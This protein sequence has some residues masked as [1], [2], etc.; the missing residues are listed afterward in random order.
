VTVEPCEDFR[1]GICLESDIDGFKT[2]ACRVNKWQDCSAQGNSQDCGNS[3]RRDCKWVDKKCVAKYPPGFDFWE[4]GDA[5]SICSS[6][7]VQCTVTYEK[8]LASEKKCVQNCECL[9]SS[10]KNNQNQ[11]CVSLGDCGSKTNYLG[12][13]G[14]H[15]GG[16]VYSGTTEKTSSS[17][18]SA[19]SS[20]TATSTT[21]KTNSS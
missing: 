17:G 19:S 8:K 18:S 11:I 7:N 14:Y 13:A 2:A 16:A 6:A 1:Q 10:W 9:E 21:V 4:E 3:D 15:D 5:Q 12:Y 20:N